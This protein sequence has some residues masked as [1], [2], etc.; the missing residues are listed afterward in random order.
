MKTI[1]HN[2]EAT[3]YSKN[4]HFRISLH[5]NCEITAN[6]CSMTLQDQNEGNDQ[7]HYYLSSYSL[8]TSNFRFPDCNSYLGQ[9]VW[10][11]LPLP[12]EYWGYR[13][14]PSWPAPPTQFLFCINLKLISVS[15]RWTQSHRIPLLLPLIKCDNTLIKPLFFKSGLT[16]LLGILVTGIWA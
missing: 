4:N 2:W 15:Q 5:L 11:F 10:T 3:S 9:L 1:T 12:L 7:A 8:I 16:S 6:L 14:A 13:L